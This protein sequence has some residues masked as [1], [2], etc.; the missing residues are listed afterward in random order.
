MAQRKRQTLKGYFEVG[1]IPTQQN[2]HDWIES[3]VMLSD[4]N[5]GS[6]Q[7]TGSINLVGIDGNLT[8][9]Q[10]ISASGTVYAS[11]F[12]PNIVTSGIISSSAITGTSNFGTEIILDNNT[13]LQGKDLADIPR[14]LI[15]FDSSNTNII[16][17]QAYTTNLLGSN[18]N[19]N[20]AGDISLDA[21]GD[22]V[23]FKDNG[24]TTVFINTNKGHITASGNIEA[25]G[26]I[27]ASGTGSFKEVKIFNTPTASLHTS[28][29][30]S[31]II[32][33]NLPTTKPSTIG[34]LWLGDSDLAGTSKQLM[35]V[36]S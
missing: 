19:V 16:C 10:N 11:S 30:S 34:S 12:E 27:S 31:Q 25:S 33:E 4:D 6:I 23:F 32:F 36:T 20:A 3:N 35:V 28:G 5:S 24:T 18:V 9:S 14:D 1:D 26:N 15:F 17:N 2:Y 22:D 13:I 8:A 29:A 21:S 7:L